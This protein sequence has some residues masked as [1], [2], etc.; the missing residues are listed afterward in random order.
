[1]DP[2]AK[3]KITQPVVEM[4]GDEM[5]RIIWSEI[6]TK[7]RNPSRPQQSCPCLVQLMATLVSRSHICI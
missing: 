6:K 7:V 1:M 5:T 2:V 3:I 4:D